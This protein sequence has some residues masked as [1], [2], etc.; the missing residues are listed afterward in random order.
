MIIH[1]ADYLKFIC[2]E[3][4]GW[5]GN[6]DLK[7][8]T[9]LQ[10]IGTEVV[11]KREPDFWINIVEEFINVFQEDF[12]VFIIPDCRFPNE[13]NFLK[14]FN[15]DVLTVRVIRL[16][17]E[18]KLTLEQR[19]HPSETSLDNYNFDYEIVS[20]SGLDKLEKEVNKLFEC[21]KILQIRKENDNSMF[22]LE[23]MNAQLNYCKQNNLPYF[24]P[25]DGKCFR[26]GVQVYYLISATKAS[27][28]LITV[29]PNCNIS[30]CD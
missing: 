22:T 29:C 15:Y 30:F 8:R 24:V 21:V 5:D 17:H 7:G 16:N 2:K 1:N 26:C 6:K 25:Y 18:N 3:Y 10:H 11:R 23:K 20:K 9:I 12:D 4:F 19:K 28:E 27:S 13:I 14:Q